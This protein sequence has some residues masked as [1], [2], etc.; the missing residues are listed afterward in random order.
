MVSG[1]RRSGFFIAN[2]CKQYQEL[3]CLAKPL[4]WSAFS[5]LRGTPQ[6]GRADAQVMNQV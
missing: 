1:Q 5:E 6:G 2:F 3:V 4:R